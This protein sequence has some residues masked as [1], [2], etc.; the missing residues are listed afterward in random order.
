MLYNLLYGDFYAIGTNQS[1]VRGTAQYFADIDPDQIERYIQGLPLLP[2]EQALHDYIG[3]L[4]IIDVKWVAPP[5]SIIT[6]VEAFDA[7]VFA[8]L[9]EDPSWFNGDLKRRTLYPT[10]LRWADPS[11]RFFTGNPM[12]TFGRALSFVQ[13]AFGFEDVCGS[14]MPLTL[15]WGTINSL[16]ALWIMGGMASPLV[17]APVRTD[18][19][20]CSDA[21]ATTVQ[22]YNALVTTLPSINASAAA[23]IDAL[24]ISV[25]QILLMNQS[26][27]VVDSEPILD[28]TWAF[29][30]WI[31]IYD[32]VHNER[33]VV[34]IQGDVGTYTMISHLYL[35]NTPVPLEP[36]AGLGPYLW[37]LAT[38]TTV[39]L[40]TVAAALL[41]VRL[42]GW[43][44]HVGSHWFCFQ[45]V[46]GSVWMSRNLLLV[47]S[48][49]AT[50]CLAT[51]PLSTSTV[52]SVTR[53]APANRFGSYMSAL[54]FVFLLCAREDKHGPSSCAP[55]SPVPAVRGAL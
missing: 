29:L 43:H 17:C 11:L 55:L 32:W 23:A 42:F 33:E 41:G 19:A 6:A 4:G 45:P 47:R 10:P 24:G 30:G 44:S 16:F 39:T 5:P 27:I 26:Q 7:V 8:A 2:V 21:F 3:P 28:P 40:T 46:V 34:S 1:L 22:H 20:A 50:L 49:A 36:I 52:G 13:Q 25:F 35:P 31:T 15:E 38:I 9:A 37:V 51:V 14:Q 53:L 18:P 12:C 48:V 54:T